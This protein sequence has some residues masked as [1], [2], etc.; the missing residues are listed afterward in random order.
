MYSLNILCRHVRDMTA[1]SRLNK[2]MHQGRIKFEHC[3]LARKEAYS[4]SHFGCCE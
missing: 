2:N 1:D 4:N 3:K